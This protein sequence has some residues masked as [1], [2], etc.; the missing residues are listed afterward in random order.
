VIFPLNETKRPMRLRHLRSPI[1][2]RSSRR[3][4]SL[5]RN[6]PLRAMPSGPPRCVG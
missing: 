6:G 3:R 2:R 5:I 4:A 1:S